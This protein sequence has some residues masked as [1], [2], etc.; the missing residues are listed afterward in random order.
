MMNFAEEELSFRRYLN[1]SKNTPEKEKEN[2]GPNSA[3]PAMPPTTPRPTSK[4]AVTSPTYLRPNENIP[5]LA[6]EIISLLVGEERLKEFIPKNQQQIR[7]QQ[8]PNSVGPTTP[9]AKNLAFVLG[10]KIKHYFADFFDEE[11][12]PSH[13]Y[14]RI[15]VSNILLY[16]Y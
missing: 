12:W 6:K 16:I 14:H 1:K 5:S 4:G 3:N 2:E 13:W 8:I 9:F 15:L 10:K 7:Q 11:I